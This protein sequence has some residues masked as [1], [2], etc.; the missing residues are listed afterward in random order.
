MWEEEYNEYMMT[1]RI[2]SGRDNTMHSEI[3]SHISPFGH[4]NY[5]SQPPYLVQLCE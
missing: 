4:D 3:L 2:S 5:L 1:R